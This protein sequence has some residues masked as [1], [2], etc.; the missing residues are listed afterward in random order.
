[1]VCLKVLSQHFLWSILRYY[2]SIFQEKLRKSK[3]NLGYKSICQAEIKNLRIHLRH[4]TELPESYEPPVFHCTEPKVGERHHVLLG[5]WEWYVE[6]CFQVMQNPWSNP[7]CIACLGQCK[8]TSPHCEPAA[9]TVLRKNTLCE[10][11]VRVPIDKS[12]EELFHSSL[13]IY[14]LWK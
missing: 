13:I 4:D 8:L 1:M 3:A 12:V 10:A 6:V 9:E 7:G 5:Q 2:D 14:Y 11:H